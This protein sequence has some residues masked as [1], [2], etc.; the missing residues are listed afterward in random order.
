MP[1][2]VYAS[3]LTAFLTLFV[4]VDPIG[5]IPLV[6]GFFAGTD[7]KRRNHV[8]ITSVAAALI[9]GILFLFLGKYVLEKLGIGVGD[10]KVA[11]GV[12]LFILAL[13]AMITGEQDKVELDSLGAVPI[14]VPLI[15][16]PATLTSLIILTD[17]YGYG[18]SLV[19]YIVNVFIAGIVLAAGRK[20]TS[21]FGKDGA[22][23]LSKVAMLLLAAFAVMMIRVGIVDIIREIEGGT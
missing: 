6:E 15:A 22:S 12:L 23:V 9:V 11:G 21:I 10:F 7:S 1:G 19:A 5:L 8:L 4:A 3:F 13:R 17:H 18:I 14:G 2:N 16:G 20:L